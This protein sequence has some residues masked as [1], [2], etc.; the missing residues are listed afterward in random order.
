VIDY[1]FY[2]TPESFTR[3]LFKAL[4]DRGHWIDGYLFEPCVGS[5]A[6]LRATPQGEVG[7]PRDAVWSTN[8]L[9][10]SWPADHHGDARSFRLLTPV[11]WAI[12]NPPFT[13]AIDIIENMLGFAKVGV[14]MHLRASIHEV[15]KTGVRRTWMAKHLPTGILWLP[16]F[17]YQRSKLD[18][19]WKTDSVCACWVIWLK[20]GL[21]VE[22]GYGPRGH[23][24]SF[25][26]PAPQFIDYAPEWVLDALKKETPIYR[27]RMDKLMEAR[28]KAMG[29]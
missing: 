22:A 7:S 27:A 3:Y 9:D 26:Q 11:D 4:A 20:P 15:L 2:E 19:E 25:Q 23:G 5:G 29:V 14:A 8:D 16:R 10:P 13:P 18:G 21:A 12:S 1:E 17:A 28:N 24:T 6:I